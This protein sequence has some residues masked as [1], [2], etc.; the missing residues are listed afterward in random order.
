MTK[1]KYRTIPPEDWKGKFYE[2]MSIKDECINQAKI[3][4]KN[5]V[6]GAKVYE[7]TYDG[8][9]I[10]KERQIFDGTDE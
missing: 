4:T 9:K 1:I 7:V 3:M 8:K 10:V 6:S 5:S 2:F